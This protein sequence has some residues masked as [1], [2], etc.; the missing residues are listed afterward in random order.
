[1]RALAIVIIS[2]LLLECFYFVE[3]RA[4]KPVVRYKPTPYCR[5]PCDTL[6]QCGPP[7]PKC[8]RRYWSSQVC[9]K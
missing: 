6:K 4:R 8:P 3:C 1:M 7:C 2:L 5:Q 9:E